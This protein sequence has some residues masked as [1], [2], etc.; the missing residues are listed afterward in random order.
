VMLLISSF[1]LNA[2]ETIQKTG[3]TITAK[4]TSPTMFHPSRPAD[5]V[6]T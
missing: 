2:V 1:G 6:L 4:T 5:R 3:N